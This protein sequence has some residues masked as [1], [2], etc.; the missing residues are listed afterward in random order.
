[1]MAS[2]L[3]PLCDAL[4]HNRE[5]TKAQHDILLQ[6]LEGADTDMIALSILAHDPQLPQLLQYIFDALLRTSFPLPSESAIPPIQQKALHFL[7]V[8]SLNHPDLLST[9]ASLAPLDNLIPVFFNRNLKDDKIVDP[10][11]SHLLPQIQFLTAISCSSAINISSTESLHCLFSV[12]FSAISIK[13]LSVWAVSSIACFARNSTTSLSFLRSLPNFSAIKREIA[14]LLSSNDHSLVVSALSA[15]SVLF[16]RGIDKETAM[17]V[18]VAAVCA[19][20]EYQVLTTIASSVILQLSD[21]ISLT[22]KDIE[23]LFRAAMSSRGMR[24]YVI[25]KLL[26]EIG[27]NGHKN[28]LELLQ[29][30]IFFNTLLQS[31]LESEDGFVTVAGAHLLLVLFETDSISTEID[32]SDSFEK[33][34]H[35]IISEKVEDI[36]KLEAYLLIVRLLISIRESM[37]QI[38]RYLQ[39]KEDLIFVSFQR[40]IES[41]NSFVVIHFFLFIFAASH[42]FKHWL[43]KLREIVIDSQFSAL[44]VHVLQNSLNRRTLDDA[45]EV[46]QIIIGGITPKRLRLDPSLSYTV[47]S[48][49]FLLN[50]Q[51]KQESLILEQKYQQLQQ[52]YM[53]QIDEF[54]VEK[55]CRERELMALKEAADLSMSQS[56]MNEQKI[57]DLSAQNEAMMK[58]LQAKKAKLMKTIEELK[59]SESK[60]ND[61]SLLVNQHEMVANTSTMKSKKLK[62]KIQNMKQIEVEKQETLKTNEQLRQR[63]KEMQL[64]NE[65]SVKELENMINVATK[66]R[67]S[68]KETEKLLSEAQDR[69]NQLSSA[70]ELEK[71]KNEEN[72]KQTQRFELII[73]KKG[74]NEI[75]LTES[76]AKL[77]SEIELLKQKMESLEA[78]NQRLKSLNDKQCKRIVELRKD[79]KEL[80]ALA[81]L[82]HKIT[83]GKLE[84][85]ESIVGMIDNE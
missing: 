74:E 48:G 57:T 85:V 68:R 12:L 28:A 14:S 77:N 80:A 64:Q 69:I 39:D 59:L 6:Y 16:S 17:R 44:L 10:Q 23:N 31:I 73:K 26:I 43:N 41:N 54:S 19:P 7:T 70:I 75:Q 52:K 81:Q 62:T 3:F 9:V 25:Y 32:I 5:N 1:M 61:L 2:P 40:H 21:E 35:S 84:N 27:G 29:N 55:E 20:P 78:D 53:D 58:K 24:S 34:M 8:I 15:I 76:I 83:D 30:K 72:E 42:F 46:L 13:Q 51:R 11:L 33:A 67:N 45:L 60:L 18:S 4:N 49:F 65:G 66:E 22:Q 79:R 38:V 71:Q 36:D 50:R 47:A 56:S 63:V 82:I 37:T